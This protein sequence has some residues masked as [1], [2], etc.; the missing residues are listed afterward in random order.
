MNEWPVRMES[1]KSRDQYRRIDSFASRK[2]VALVLVCHDSHG[3]L[4][5]L[6]CGRNRISPG[7]DTQHMVV[8]L[9]SETLHPGNSNRR[10]F[11]EARIHR[12]H[13]PAACVDGGC[14]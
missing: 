4:S 1:F 13:E 14:H 12:L 3:G 9:H 8:L 5:S 10:V 7:A 2:G 6:V 11:V